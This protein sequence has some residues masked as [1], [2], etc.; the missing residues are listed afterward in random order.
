MGRVIAMHG[1]A[2]SCSISRRATAEAAEDASGETLLRQRAAARRAA[3]DWMET[4]ARV[5]DQWRALM[6]G[7]E[8]DQSLIGALDAHAAFLNEAAARLR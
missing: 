8:S 7:I 1:H 4:Q 5:L 6:V 3:L 2:P